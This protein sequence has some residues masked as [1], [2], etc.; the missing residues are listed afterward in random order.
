LERPDD[1]F[2]PAWRTSG[3]RQRASDAPRGIVTTAAL[4]TIAPSRAIA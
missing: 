2:F 4:S 3:Q 1:R